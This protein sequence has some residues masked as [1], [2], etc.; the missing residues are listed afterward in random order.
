M[1]ATMAARRT[2]RLRCV[3]HGRSWEI[4]SGWL[5]SS[6]PISKPQMASVV[7][8]FADKSAASHRFQRWSRRTSNDRR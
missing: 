6:G 3:A 1:S 7:A 8:Q 4:N 5:A 2:Q